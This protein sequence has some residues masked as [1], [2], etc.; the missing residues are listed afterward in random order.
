[1]E[2]MVRQ[3]DQLINFTREIN[4]RIAESGV[5]GVEGLVALYDQLR[6]ALAKVSTQ[7]LDWAQGEVNRVLESLKRLSDELAH[8]A[9]LKTALQTGH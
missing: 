6:N 5:S 7:E 1:M 8:L 2:E 3:T 9:A 4:R